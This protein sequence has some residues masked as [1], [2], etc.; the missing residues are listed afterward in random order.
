MET[1]LTGIINFGKYRGKT[2][3]EILDLDASYL[4]WA[5]KNVKEFK[6]SRKA[7]YDVFD[8]IL[9]DQMNKLYKDLEFREENERQIDSAVT[10]AKNT[11]NINKLNNFLD[12][13]SR[14]RDEIDP[15]FWKDKNDDDRAETE[16]FL[17]SLDDQELGDAMGFDINEYGDH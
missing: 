4:L 10:T 5:D 11:N 3:A 9:K 2:I 17:N 6:L 12:N 8:G 13:T 14:F 7:L 15:P 16:F 1:E